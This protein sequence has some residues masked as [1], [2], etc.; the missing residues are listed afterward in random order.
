M[1]YLT[2]K[3]VFE[4]CTKHKYVVFR[5]Y[6]NFQEAINCKVITI[7]KNAKREIDDRPTDYISF[8][9]CSFSEYISKKIGFI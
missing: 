1:K 3:E 2:R 7:S 8:H 6:N 9:A 4:I 5:L